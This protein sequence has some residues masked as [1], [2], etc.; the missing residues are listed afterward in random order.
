MLE[1]V[2]FPWSPFCIVQRRILEFSGR[3]FKI[4]NISSGDRSLVW[5]LTRQRYY[6]VPGVRD[7]REVVFETD[8]AS[9]V[10]A[11]YLDQRLEL[12]LFPKRW[13][14]I[15]DILWQYFENEIE[16]IGFKLNDIYF[17]E[18][19]P[20]KEHLGF[21]RYKERKFGRGCIEQWRDQQPALLA[22]LEARLLPC[23]EMLLARDFLLDDK[24]RFTDFDLFGMLGNFLY[25]GHYALPGPHQKLAAWYERMAKL[26]SA[27][28]ASEKLHTRY[29]RPSPRSKLDTQFRRQ[30]RP[31]THRGS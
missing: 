26:K 4:T 21:I 1:L 25:S 31:H 2:Q 3:K 12:D 30:Q 17:E 20:A 23:E 10:I 8:G 5:K 24:P 15:Q 9:Q 7:G 19:V 6:Q 29:E 13:E 22:E 14:G 28:P 16:G 18:I 27:S 11:K